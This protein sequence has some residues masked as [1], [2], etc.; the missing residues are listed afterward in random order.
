[1]HCELQVACSHR[2]LS[3]NPD[4]R[5]YF[6]AVTEGCVTFLYSGC[7]GNRNRFLALAKCRETCETK[8]VVA[9]VDKEERKARSAVVIAEAVLG[10]VLVL[11]AAAAI[12][13]GIKYYRAIKDRQNYRVFNNNNDQRGGARA[14]TRERS[15]ST[16][17]TRGPLPDAMQVQCCCQTYKLS[18]VYAASHFQMA[19]DNPAYINPS[20]GFETTYEEAPVSTI[21]RNQRMEAATN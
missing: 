5:Y 1:M 18:I 9:A 2:A 12:L 16:S 6:D 4:F 7:G 19:Y 11:L 17:S 15:N 10:A 8:K 21:S 13:L 14:T 20:D 3:V